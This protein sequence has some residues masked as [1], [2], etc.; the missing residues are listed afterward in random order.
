[1]S[2]RACLMLFL[3]GLAACGGESTGNQT[4]D[5][6]RVISA[7][8]DQG[9]VV[10]Y[11]TP[12]LSFRIVG[13]ADGEWAHTKLIDANGVVLTELAMSSQLGQYG[14]DAM[15]NH[16][17][18]VASRTTLDRVRAEQ[19]QN[20]VESML[21]ILTADGR[22]D[23]DFL[24][25]NIDLVVDQVLLLS[26]VAAGGVSTSPPC[27]DF[28]ARPGDSAYHTIADHEAQLEERKANGE[29][30]EKLA[31]AWYNPC[32]LHDY[33]CIACG[34][35]TNYSW[36]C[37]WNCTFGTDCMGRCGGGCAD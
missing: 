26:T 9:L 11:T 31:C 5:T 23:G 30:I 21:P 32:C 16:I 17:E 15:M 22:A 28:L 33:A 1:M 14:G 3:G 29:T 34:V 7:N 8:D 10:A 24:G 36:A 4:A 13:R 20:A 2:M 37:G 18:E 25:A 27:P 6:V 12:E 19:L 35:G